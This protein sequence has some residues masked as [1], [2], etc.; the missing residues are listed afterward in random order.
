MD[1]DGWMA[2]WMADWIVADRCTKRT[3]V[4]FN[5]N[6]NV[7]KISMFFSPLVFC[8]F[9]LTLFLSLF[10]Q[11]F[12]FDFPFLWMHFEKIEQKQLR[13]QQQLSMTTQFARFMCNESYRYMV[14]MA[15]TIL[16]MM[17]VLCFL[18]SIMIQLTV[19]QITH[20]AANRASPNGR[21]HF[22]QWLICSERNR[23]HWPDD[24]YSSRYFEWSIAIA[25]LI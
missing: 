8:F 19:Y 25:K 20:M 12:L 23:F 2:G 7:I 1:M 5:S 15:A 4:V 17:M 11:S 21:N 9:N 18:S 22:L 10:R 24:D 16:I 3:F 14:W 13:E 6:I